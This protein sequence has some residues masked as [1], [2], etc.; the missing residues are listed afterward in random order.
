MFESTLELRVKVSAIFA[1]SSAGKTQTVLETKYKI[2]KRLVVNLG[3][4]LNSFNCFFV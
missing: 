3:T 1:F 4:L 2:S